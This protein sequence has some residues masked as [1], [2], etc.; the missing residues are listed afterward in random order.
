[1]PK[2]QTSLNSTS[3]NARIL[4]AL[5]LCL[6]F[7]ASAFV[8]IQA[9]LKSYSPESVALLRFL[10]ASAILAIYAVF[11]RIRLPH[12]NDFPAIVFA[13]FLGFT[14]YNLSLNYGQRTVSAGAASFLYSSVSIFTAILA[15]IFL[16]ERIKVWGWAGIITSFAGVAFITLGERSGWRFGLGAFLVLLA[17]F[18]D[19]LYYIIQ[20]PYLTKYTALEFTS[21]AVW[22]G[23]CLLL[24][25]LPRLLEELEKASLGDTLAV[26]YL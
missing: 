24:P 9:A 22:A 15:I 23:T 14:L 13:G 8:G 2:L 7:W 17:A 18:S 25:F 16:R 1:M 20:K 21:Y 12:V 26:V 3:L 6:F 5:G 19:S 10:T 11:S 4:G